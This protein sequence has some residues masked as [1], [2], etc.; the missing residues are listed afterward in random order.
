MAPL[1]MNLFE[2]LP[3]EL[4]LKIYRYLLG[5]EYCTENYTTCEQ[6]L[7]RVKR[8]CQIASLR[9]SVGPLAATR[10][11]DITQRYT[12]HTAIFRLNRAIGE[13][14]RRLFRDC[15]HFVRLRCTATSALGEMFD[16]IPHLKHS[17]VRGVV[18]YVLVVAVIGTRWLR[19]ECLAEIDIV[20]GMAHLKML[21][22]WLSVSKCH[23]GLARHPD[24]AQIKPVDLSLGPSDHSD[25]LNASTLITELS[26]ATCNHV[27]W[28]VVH[29]GQLVHGTFCITW[30]SLVH[31]SRFLADQAALLAQHGLLSPATRLYK[32]ITL[33]VGRLIFETH[34]Q[35][36][37]INDSEERRFTTQYY[38]HDLLDCWISFATLE[39]GVHAWGQFLHMNVSP[40]TG[41]QLIDMWEPP[42]TVIGPW[43]P[44]WQAPTSAEELM[45]ADTAAI[46]WL[47]ATAH[48]RL[49]RPINHLFPIRWASAD[50]PRETASPEAWKE[51][52][53]NA[54]VS[55]VI[56]C[57]EKYDR[58]LLRRDGLRPAEWD[59]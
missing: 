38:K 57:K 22:A 52:I 58:K 13:E 48:G 41:G 5:I 53:D 19:N 46:Y 20:I 40:F 18:P 44:V 43:P 33:F 29:E 7:A 37:A 1:N 16:W 32:A 10:G 23:G 3:V 25:P 26:E 9:R 54:S 21:L 35:V 17:R 42:S 56:W 59:P 45:A 50:R 34:A 27:Q 2:M 14:S 47:V 30:H 6:E 4:R 24:E 31:A 49:C 51:I 12:F 11:L 39:F 28:Q 36:E 8:F 55:C 15:N